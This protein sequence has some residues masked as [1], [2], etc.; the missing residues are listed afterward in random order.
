MDICDVRKNDPNLSHLVG[1]TLEPPEPQ[2]FPD[3]LRIEYPEKRAEHGGKTTLL[4]A[5]L[6]VNMK[7]RRKTR[8]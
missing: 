7:V 8:R 2:S 1:D 4:L 5:L 6:L 3:S